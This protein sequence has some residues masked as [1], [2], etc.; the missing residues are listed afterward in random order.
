MSKVKNQPFFSSRVDRNRQWIY[1][2][3]QVINFSHNPC[4]QQICYSM[5]YKFMM[6][7]ADLLSLPNKVWETC[8]FYSV[9]SSSSYYYYSLSSLSLSLSPF[10]LR[11]MNLSTAETTGQNF[12]KLCGVIDICF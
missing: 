2:F 6:L 3:W 12:M 5:I 11:T 8:C 1:Y 9:S 4:N 7:S 10:F